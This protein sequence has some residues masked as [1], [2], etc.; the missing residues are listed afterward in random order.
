MLNT[1]QSETRT[2]LTNFWLPIPCLLH[3]APSP[4]SEPSQPYCQLHSVQGHMIWKLPEIYRVI[5][6]KNS[7][8]LI[9]AG[10]FMKQNQSTEN[11]TPSSSPCSSLHIR[12]GM[13]FPAPSQM[14][15][16]IAL[17]SSLNC[18]PMVIHITHDL[19]SRRH[20]PADAC[21]Q[22]TPHSVALYYEHASCFLA[23]ICF[24]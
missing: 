15:S 18:C 10:R 8:D 12:T 21:S 16:P 19:A 24:M 14:S 9:P 1:Q 20:R 5:H 22:N 6:W 23:Q 4:Q 7:N 3:Y 17:L 11:P 2:D 13:F